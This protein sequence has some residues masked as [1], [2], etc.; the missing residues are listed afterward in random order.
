MLKDIWSLPDSPPEAL[1]GF[2][3]ARKSFQILRELLCH[4]LIPYICVDLSTSEQLVHLSAAAHLLLTLFSE[5]TTK[6]MPTQLYI[7][8]MIMIKNVYFCVAKTKADNPDG[9]FWI[10]LLGTDCLEVLYG[11]LY[12]MVG[13]D[14]NLDLLQ[15]SLHLTGTTEVST[16]LA[17]YPH[18]D[19]APSFLHY[20]KMDWSSMS[21]SIISTLHLGMEM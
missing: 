5:D 1:P 10:I 6:L 3:Q 13:N 4:I 7:D 2:N 16:I 19:R 21:M 8:I 18:W 9:N 15:L 17:K 11:I 14:A 12:T 20:Q